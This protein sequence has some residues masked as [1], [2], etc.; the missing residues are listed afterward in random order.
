MGRHAGFLTAASALARVHPDDGPH[1]IYLPERPF[2]MDRFVADVQA[3]YQKLGRCVI[4][5]SE[6]IADKNGDPIAAQ[7]IK[8]KDAHGNAQLSGLGALGDML[9]A[10]IKDKAQISRVRADTFGYLQRSFPGIASPTDSREARQV[11]ILAVKHAM[12]MES[13]SIAIRRKPGKKYQVFFEPVPLR[14]VAKDTR[15]VPDEFISPAGNDVT[16]AFIEY[17]K[18]LVGDLPI[19]GRFKAVRV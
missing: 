15:H 16:A 6:G 9:A 5:V 17:A 3:V 14:N 2:D 1:L 4:A 18:P 10:V 19:I 12:K 7:F 8:E 13:G 11:G